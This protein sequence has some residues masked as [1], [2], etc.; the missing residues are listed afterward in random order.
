[1]SVTGRLVEAFATTWS[2]IQKRHPDVPPVVITMASSTT[3]G[4]MRG[5]HG[6]FGFDRW[7]QDE[8]KVSELF[9]S[10]E[11]L[12]RGAVPV[13]GTLIHEATHGVAKIRGVQDTSRQG[14]YHNKQF[15][16]LGEELGLELARDASLGWST[17]TVPAVTQQ[18]YS[19][20]LAIIEP[21]LVAYRL[22]ERMPTERKSTNL[23]VAMCQCPRK[24]RVARGTLDEAPIVCA[25]C[26]KVFDLGFDAIA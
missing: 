20:Q 21:A 18:A 6:H 22:A 8:T 2:A 1:M 3:G 7:Q 16:A 14:R 24:I 12:Q 11:G 17:T 25:K 5:K 15:K 9:V 4:P 13:L 26:K 10:G 19:R 23:L